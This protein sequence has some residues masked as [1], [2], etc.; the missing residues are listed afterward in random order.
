MNTALAKTKDKF[1]TLRDLLLSRQDEIA[2]SMPNHLDARRMIQVALG[3]ARTNPR[4]LDCSQASL[5][6]S[7]MS[8]CQLG[9]ELDGILGHAYIVPFKNKQGGY[10]AQLQI[11]YRGMLS[12]ARRSGE[13][14]SVSAHV[15]RTN[16]LFSF[17]YGLNE[18]LQHVPKS[19]FSDEIT[20]AYAVARFK[21]GGFAFVV[22]DREEI[23]YYRGFSKAKNSPAWLDNYPAMAMKTAIRQLFRYLPCSS[24]VQRA[25]VA[26]E[27]SDMGI[28]VPRDVV[29][30][31]GVVESIE[32]A[33][34][35]D[36]DKI[37][38]GFDEKPS[39]DY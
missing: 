26:D 17:E 36:T 3:A 32:D 15:V 9:L 29:S 11:G 33:S 25:V 23:E 12:L 5:V 2:K 31:D 14:K 19:K 35:V 4:L 18:D 24:E 28:S 27:Y 20:H 1:N 34:V 13:I 38:E 8:A 7:V 10:D 6:S 30:V 39:Q 16:D 22:I 21:D 37:A